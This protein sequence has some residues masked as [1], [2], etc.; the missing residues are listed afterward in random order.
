MAEE[1]IIAAFETLGIFL[2][3]FATVSTK[4][5]L[6]LTEL[7]R[8][9]YDTFKEAIKKTEISNP[10]FTEESLRNSFF[11]LGTM[12][13]KGKLYEWISAYPKP[14]YTN[15]VKNIGLISAGNIPLVAF[16][17][18]LAVLITG[19]NLHLKMSSKDNILF[20]EIR[21]ILI[22][23]SDDFEEKIRIYEG[24]LENIEAV[25]ATGSDNSSRYFEYYFGKYPHIIRSNR[26]SVAVLSGNE[27]SNQLKK[28]A[29]DVFM[30]FG[31]G[32][33]N[34]SKIYVPKDYDP[35]IILDNFSHY[36]YY[37]NHTKYANNYDYQ[38]AI[39]LIN[40]VPFLDNG[41]LIFRE[42]NSL[43]SPLAC[44]HYE[45]YN[46][47][48][49]LKI[50]IDRDKDKIQCIVSDPEYYEGAI[51]FGNSQYPDLKDFADNVDSIKFLLNLYEK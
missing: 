23:L 39:L 50:L 40:I 42:N 12:L 5:N 3:Q 16:H 18:I 31:L 26:N 8:L 15:K 38:R 28:L 21:K 14:E 27:T 47:M 20:P 30:Y 43:N 9:Y 34:V 25:I 41:F 51:D 33:R 4:K 2:Q 45:F 36:D 11:A 46:S 37:G 19:H 6:Q 13:E 17:D 22:Y 44:L 29:D 35:R 32:C 24:K 49:E 7:N 10:W 48:E 1:S